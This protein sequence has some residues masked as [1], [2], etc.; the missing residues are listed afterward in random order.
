MSDADKT[1]WP[2][3][4]VVGWVRGTHPD[5]PI[6]KV[7][8][9]LEARCRSGRIRARGR[10]RIYNWDRFPKI[11]HTDIGFVLCSEEYSYLDPSPEPIRAGEWRD[12]TFFA[13][14]I[15]QP[16]EEYL[17][18]F[19]R[20]LNQSNVPVELRSKSKYRLAWIDV[21]FL[22]EDVVREWP[23]EGFA[24]EPTPIAQKI[25]G[26]PFEAIVNGSAEARPSARR[27]APAA[28]HQ[29]RTWYQQRMRELSARGETSSGEQDYVAAKQEFG[30]RVTRARLRAVRE[31][32]APEQ[33]RQQ[34]RRAARSES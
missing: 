31:E 3:G 15:H 33:W 20:A 32:L 26:S 16:G 27:M 1:W 30:K 23:N 18:G 7:R 4:H 14:P 22:R 29:L 21:E 19:E 11:S 24:A 8:V 6:R 17:K 2:L 13:R 25:A 9:G 10:R 28:D 5:S 34:G 12:L